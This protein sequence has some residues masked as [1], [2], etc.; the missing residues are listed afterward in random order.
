MSLEIIY[1]QIKLFN[2]DTNIVR[3]KPLVFS[4]EYILNY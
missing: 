3:D 1:K 4:N 2:V